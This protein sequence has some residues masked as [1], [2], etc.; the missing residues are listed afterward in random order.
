MTR[1]VTGNTL[2]IQVL[3]ALGIDPNNVCAVQIDLACNQ[4][5]TIQITRLIKDEEARQIVDHLS[6]YRIEPA[7]ARGAEDD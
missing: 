5:A 2:G 3:E 6:K 1:L 4:A 7:D